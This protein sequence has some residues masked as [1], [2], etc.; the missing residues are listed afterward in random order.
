MTGTPGSGGERPADALDL[1][2]RVSAKQMASTPDSPVAG[3]VHGAPC[4]RVP[5]GL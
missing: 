4:D 1:E 2:P 5:D 3:K